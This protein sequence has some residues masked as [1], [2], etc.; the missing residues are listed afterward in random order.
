MAFE[1]RDRGERGEEQRN[2]EQSLDWEMVWEGAITIGL[3]SGRRDRHP[4]R[5]AGVPREPR[6]P[7]PLIG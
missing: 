3:E 6:Y 5:R 7:N 1:R 2:A 4:A